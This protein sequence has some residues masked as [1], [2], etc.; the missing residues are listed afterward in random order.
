[1]A[2][3][4]LRFGVARRD[5]QLAGSLVRD[6]STE[7]RQGRDAIGQVE[8]GVVGDREDELTIGA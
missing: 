5:G 8:A 1:M 4:A 3:R 6:T 2:G 7:A